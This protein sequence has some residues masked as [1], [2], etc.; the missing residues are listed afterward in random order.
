MFINNWPSEVVALYGQSTSF[1]PDF[2]MM[3]ARKLIPVS[4]FVQML[5]AIRNKVLGFVLDIER[6]NPEAGDGA[7]GGEPVP[8]DRVTQI[9]NTNIY[10]GSNVWAAGSSDVTQSPTQITVGDWNALREAL[11]AIGLPDEDI[12]D[13]RSAVD[14]DRAAGA[15]LSSET[16]QV[17]GWLGRTTVRLASG[18]LAV[19][20]NDAA[21]GIIAG[22]VLGFLGHH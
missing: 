16:S 19:T 13:L 10:G 12:Q 14:H 3:S 11:A 22:L 2:N 8:R 9:F 6:E 1:L 21:G 5:D 7:V 20:S 18:A 15:D 17:K 4:Q